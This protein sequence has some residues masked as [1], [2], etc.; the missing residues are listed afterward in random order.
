[1]TKNVKKSWTRRI[2]AAAV[3]TALLTSGG[4]VSS[5]HDVSVLAGDGPGRCC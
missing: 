4:L 2:T 3:L 5:R 1:M